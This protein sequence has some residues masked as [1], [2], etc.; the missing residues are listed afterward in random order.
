MQIAGT[1]RTATLV[2]KLPKGINW[3]KPKTKEPPLLSIRP[4]TNS[5]KRRGE[6]PRVA[7]SH[8]RVKDDEFDYG[9]LDDQDLLTAMANDVED[10]F[11][12]IDEY[13]NDDNVATAK[14]FK[15]NVR[16]ASVE[17]TQSNWEAKKMANGKWYCNH[18]C[19]DRS[20]CKHMC[21][22]E[23]LDKPPKAPKKAAGGDK[24]DL[25][26][27]TQQQKALPKGQTTLSLNK[28]A[29]ANS[30][31]AAGS[32]VAQ[33]D[34]TQE[35]KK[36]LSRIPEEMKR[37]ERLHS[38]T[39]GDRAVNTPTI[40]RQNITPSQQTDSRPR[41]SFMP[42]H[43]TDNHHDINSDYGDSWPDSDLP[44]LATLTD[45]A[46]HNTQHQSNHI[47][48][49]DND[50]SDRVYDHENFGD[51]DSLMNEAMVG[52]ADS[53]EL[54][55]QNDRAPT[56]P[57]RIAEP[58]G[59][60]VMTALEDSLEETPT[61]VMPET[62]EHFREVSRQM[63]Y[64]PESSIQAP[65][66]P[67]YKHHRVGPFID[68]SSDLLVTPG[69]TLRRPKCSTDGDEF[70]GP[71]RKKMKIAN[72]AGKENE[73]P[74]EPTA[75]TDH[76]DTEMAVQNEEQDAKVKREEVDEWFMQEFGQYVDFT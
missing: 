52:L 14:G 74:V 3:P 27:S 68:T 19:K 57:S 23:G 72:I 56:L 28:S 18:R 70:G 44:D 51:S 5:A 75:L 17:Q 34:L 8:R 25:P 37:L 54:G 41:L 15:Q 4:A 32:D 30:S 31:T 9:G 13:G 24:N 55:M 10:E 58:H 7:Q 1:L 43:N 39:M 6:S 60:D 66:S 42:E 65:P 45:Y 76:A 71:S 29:K 59:E 2:P 48:E 73:I 36:A 16:T 64:L 49:Q 21:C 38:K 61:T 69:S 53:Q 62:P 35:P 47:P 67:A 40:P 33:L 12:H 50:Y 63:M 46:K 20:A 11:K 22:R 26:R